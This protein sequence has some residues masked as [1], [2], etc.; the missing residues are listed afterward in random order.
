MQS[1]GSGLCWPDPGCGAR[2]RPGAEGARMST[3]PLEKVQ[4]AV[5][6]GQ[7]PAHSRLTV[8]RIEA[9]WNETC[10]CG[11]TGVKSLLL[12]QCNIEEHSSST[13]T[14]WVL[15]PVF[16]AGPCIGKCCYSF[17]SQE[18]PSSCTVCNCIWSSA[19]LVASC[20]SVLAQI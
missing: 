16:L 17:L 4:P 7:V 8:L 5:T 11:K 6:N 19:C 18:I 15:F 1:A 9:G 10:L 14:T 13:T 12:L 2:G 3:G 20:C